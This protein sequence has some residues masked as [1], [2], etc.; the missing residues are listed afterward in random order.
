MHFRTSLE[1]FPSFIH[2]TSVRLSHIVCWAKRKPQ[3]GLSCSF[4]SNNLCIP[5][6]YTSKTSF[7]VSTTNSKN[8]R[9]QR[10][11]QEIKCPYFSHGLGTLQYLTQGHTARCDRHGLDPR[12]PVPPSRLQSVPHVFLSQRTIHIT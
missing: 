3:G 9:I 12:P 1:V 2:S 5:L 6:N 4:C 10:G 7:K 11:L 8:L